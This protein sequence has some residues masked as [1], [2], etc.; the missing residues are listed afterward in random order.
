MSAADYAARH[1]L[2]RVGARPTLPAYLKQ[3][4]ARRDFA[5]EMARSRIQA[6]NQRNKLGMLWVVLKPTLNALMYGVIFGILQGDSRPKDFPVFVVIGVFLFEFFSSSMTQGARSITG[7]AS[8][9]QSLAFPRMTLPLAVVIE[10]LLMLVP[11]LGVMFVY[12]TVLGAYP[13]W[14]WMMI[15]PLVM[16]FAIFNTGVALICARLTV[17]VRDLTQILPLIVRVLFYTSGVLFGVNKI[18]E[19]YPVLVRVFDFHPVYEVLQIARGSIMSTVEYPG[20]YW[21]Y[22]SIWAVVVF[23]GGV[24]FFWAAE[25]RYGRVD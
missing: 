1:Q 9:V 2:H 5:Y 24:V 23:I 16:L 21:L 10:Q 4:W 22:F 7:S 25:E 14:S 12:C 19:H 17:H 13:M 3:A 15:I 18:F 6:S 11:M 20:V 8:L